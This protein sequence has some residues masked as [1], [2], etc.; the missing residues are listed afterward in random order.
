M[1]YKGDIDKVSLYYFE[2]N[3]MCYNGKMKSKNVGSNALLKTELFYKKYIN[4][5]VLQKEFVQ[6]YNIHNLKA[7]RLIGLRGRLE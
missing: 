6:Y 5:S 7:S 3:N 2:T 1:N 4:F